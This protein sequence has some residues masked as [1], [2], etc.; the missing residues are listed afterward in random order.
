MKATIG[1]SAF[2]FAISITLFG[3]SSD[4]PGVPGDGATWQIIF[5]DDF[6]SETLDQ[7]WVLMEG[8]TDNYVLNGSTIAIDDS[9][10]NGDGPLF[11]YDES[12]TDNVIRVTCKL[13]TMAM[14]GEIQ[15]GM[16]VRATDPR[17][18]PINSDIENAYAM[19][20]TGDDLEIVKIVGGN[21]TVLASSVHPAMASNETRT[22]EGRYE[23]G[24][25]SFIIRDASGTEIGLVTATDPSPL[26]AGRVGFQGEIDNSDNEYVYVDDFK[27]EKYE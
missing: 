14:S 18:P 3:C 19:I 5:E 6:N 20:M 25:I 1:I 11:L 13:S 12:V 27:L 21:G 10:T 9:P 22:M 26:V 23:N 4:G 15:F 2:I 24:K 7:N 8:D 16:L 17:P